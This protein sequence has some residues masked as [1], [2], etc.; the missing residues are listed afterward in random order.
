MFTLRNPQLPH[1]EDLWETQFGFFWYNDPEIFTDTEADLSRK[2]DRLA[3]AGINHVITFSCTHFRWSFRRYWDLL[4]E[5]LAKIVKACHEKEIYVTE[6][7]SAH[8]T[9]NPLNAADEA[10]MDRI[11]RVRKS[12]RESWPFL[13][14]D[15]DADPIIIDDLPLSAFRQIDGRTGK[16]QRSPYRG[17]AM[18]FNNLH[19]RKAY[20]QYLESVYQTGVDGIMTDDVQWYGQACACEHCRRLFTQKTGLVLPEPGTN[21]EKWYGNYAD[22]GFRAWLD[23]KFRS[24]ENFHLAVK[25]HYESLGLK[26]L[27]PNY[28]SHNLNSNP[29]G[30]TLE[31]LPALDWIFQE[32]CF[33][34]VIRYCWPD[35]M[36]E[37]N[38]R[39]AVARRRKIPPMNMFYPDRNDSLI[40]SW[41]LSKSWGMQ[42]LATPEGKT[43]NHE[44]KH[45]RHFEQQHK[46][47]FN[48]SRKIA[49]LA[50][51]DSRR[52]RELYEHINT[53]SMPQLKC[54]MRACYHQNLAF[55]F[56]QS[57]E[58]ERLSRYNLV[59]LNEIA[60]LSDTELWALK[61]FVNSGNHLI[62]AGKTGTKDING[63]ERSLERLQQIW[64][65]SEFRPR[66]N[67]KLPKILSR[68]SGKLIL[69]PAD[70]G[71]HMLEKCYNPDRWQ[72]KPVRQPFQPISDAD[73][74]IRQ[75]LVNFIVKM[76]PGGADL[77][78][79]NL[80]E[81]VI[82]T[83]FE[84]DDAAA[85]VMHLLNATGTLKS[86]ADGTVGHADRIPFPRHEQEKPFELTFRKCNRFSGVSVKNVRLHRLQE[87]YPALLEFKD[88]RNTIVISLPAKLLIDY[89]LIE[90]TFL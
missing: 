4:N 77:V 45:L 11:L 80:P 25:Q 87:P 17:W 19:Y 88:R 63:N 65:T 53:R 69:V 44:E 23:F 1:P 16:W 81:D 29:T 9:F 86:P 52:N 83:I 89:A 15:C 14:A 42:F 12:S 46:R 50:F 10:Y 62:W 27:R 79:R 54:W 38:H 56:L 7:H 58:L 3:S 57:E 31:T 20:F 13:R 8:L 18:C 60:L 24:N 40:F 72:A 78:T 71:V 36:T 26:L 74:K 49:R 21:W 84:T 90:V 2:V 85:I 34:N 67:G 6:H 73:R 41:G 64:E 35:W 32:S 66:E 39:F 70:L 75:E 28:I 33:S 43:M 47:L 22:P 82:V 5:T 48:K 68:G 51:Y 55:D 61:A 59:V 30:Y 76:L 37:A